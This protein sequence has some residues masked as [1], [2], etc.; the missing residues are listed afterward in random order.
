MS[1]IRH[2]DSFGALFRRHV[3]C[4]LLITGVLLLL[5]FGEVEIIVTKLW[6]RRKVTRFLNLRQNIEGW[7]PFLRT[8]VL[9]TVLRYTERTKVVPMSF[10]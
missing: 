7:I 4:L 5:V 2:G 9:C 8:T 6:N 3:D 1:N 10:S